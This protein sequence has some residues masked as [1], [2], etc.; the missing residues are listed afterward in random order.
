MIDLKKLSTANPATL[1]C[2]ILTKRNQANKRKAKILCNALK[3]QTVL[4]K[5]ALF[6]AFIWTIKKTIKT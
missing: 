1:I 2:E 6:A 5:N 4:R 3:K